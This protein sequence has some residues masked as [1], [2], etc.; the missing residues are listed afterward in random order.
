VFGHPI[1][2]T[3]RERFNVT[4]PNYGVHGVAAGAVW[5]TLFGVLAEMIRQ[6]S[7]RR[8]LAMCGALALVAAMTNPRAPEPTPRV[9]IVATRRASSPLRNDARVDA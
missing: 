6:R 4:S 3:T 2:L 7:P 8:I 9:A 5:G 1:R